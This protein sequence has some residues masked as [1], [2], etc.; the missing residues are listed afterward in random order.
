MTQL[1][2]ARFVVVLSAGLFL[3]ASIL[4]ASPIHTGFFDFSGTITVTGFSNIAWSLPPQL[5]KA[6]VG[7]TAGA[8][9]VGLSGTDLTM[10]SL[11]NPP[12]VVDGLGFPAQDFIDFDGNPALSHLDINFISPGVFPAFQCA[13]PA[14]VGQVCTLPGSPFSFINAVSHDALGRPFIVSSATFAFSGVAHDGSAS[15][16][17][18]FTAQFNKS[19]QAVFAELNNVGHITNT[20][21]GTINTIE[22]SQVPE[23]GTF[24]LIGASTMALGFWRRKRRVV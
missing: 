16:N 24:I 21:S 20:Y 12:A 11:V 19:F 6:I 8:S 17:G 2:F 18:T 7:T 14:A 9:F 3:S 5:N 15:W 23:P 13:L 10:H 22:S 1:R 4:P